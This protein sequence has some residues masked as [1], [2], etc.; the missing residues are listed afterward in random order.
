MVS[1]AAA[2]LICI[3]KDSVGAAAKGTRPAPPILSL[4]LGIGLSPN[5]IGLRP[6]LREESPYLRPDL[7][8]SREAFPVGTDQA[9]KLVALVDRRDIVFGGCEP[10]GMAHPVDQQSLDIGEETA[11]RSIARCNFIPRFKGQQ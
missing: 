1:S 11:Q 6:Q 4:R 7:A 3:F 5:D 8:S 10:M 2:L 9:Y